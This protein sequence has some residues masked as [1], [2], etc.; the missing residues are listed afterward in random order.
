MTN[1]QPLYRIQFIANGDRYELY[2]REVLQSGMF[3]FIEI[4]DFVWD[5]H[6][7]LVVDP[8]HEKLK[9][10]YSGVERT[11]IP[12]HSV[13]KIDEVKKQGTAKITELGDKVT[14][15]PSPIYTNPQK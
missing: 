12:M 1:K 10:E 14:Q 8:S 2:V 13:L 11:Y 4:A 3:G 6:T 15:F 5:E 9:S 7:S